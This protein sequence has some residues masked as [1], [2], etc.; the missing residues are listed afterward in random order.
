MIQEEVNLRV[1]LYADEKTCILR[2]FRDVTRKG[3]YYDVP[4][5]A[6]YIPLSAAIYI[7]ETEKW[8]VLRTLH[9]Y[10]AAR[11]KLA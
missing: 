9:S 1:Q 10:F 8:G 3:G 4:L 5:N 11:K 7:T 6:P 2:I